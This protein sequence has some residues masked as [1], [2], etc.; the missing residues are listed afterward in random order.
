MSSAYQNQ[1]FTPA[2]RTNFE[3][4]RNACQQLM[5]EPCLLFSSIGKWDSDSYNSIIYFL[6]R[7]SLILSYIKILNNFLQKSS[8][9]CGH[10]NMRFVGICC[11]H[12]NRE[13]KKSDNWNIIQSPE[14]KWPQRPWKDWDFSWIITTQL[15]SLSLLSTVQYLHIHF[16]DYKNEKKKTLSDKRYFCLYL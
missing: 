14:F 16:L 2:T 15:I 1:G 12:K 5:N 7:I 9:N 3:S 4:N 13:R 10:K 6:P 11:T 8:M